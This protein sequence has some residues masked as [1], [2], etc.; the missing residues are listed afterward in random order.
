MVFQGFAQLSVHSFRK[1]GRIQAARYFVSSNRCEC[2]LKV[3]A[4]VI[5]AVNHVK[6]SAACFQFYRSKP[7][8]SEIAPGVNS[9]AVKRAWEALPDPFFQA[10]GPKEVFSAEFEEWEP[11]IGAEVQTLRDRWATAP[12]T[13]ADLV[14]ATRPTWLYP[15]EIKKAFAQWSSEQAHDEMLTLAELRVYAR[16]AEKIS[17]EGLI[18]D[19][20]PQ[21]EMPDRALKFFQLHAESGEAFDFHRVSEPRYR[22]AVFAHI[23]SGHRRADDFQCWIERAG[24]IAL[25]IDI[26]FNIEFGDLARPE[27]F[28]MF[29]Q[30]MEDGILLGFLGGPPCETWSKASGQALPDGSSGPRIVR[31]LAQPSGLP[32]L[33]K[34]EDDQVST[35]SRLLSVAIRLLVVAVRTGRC[36]ILEHPAEDDND[37]KLVSIWRL[38]ILRF[39]LKFSACRKVTV[40]QGYYGAKAVKPTDFF[41]VHITPDAEQILLQMRQTDLPKT[42]AIGKNT[43]N[44]WRTT[45]L[46]E[47]PPRLC[48]T[49]ALLFLKSQPMKAGSPEV[50]EW[51]LQST[52]DLR[53]MFDETVGMGQDFHGKVPHDLIRCTATTG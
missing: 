12:V 24:A 16:F 36:A 6:R 15:W 17:Y 1:H 49:L 45:E 8:V 47:Y 35:G 23:F 46:K 52:R 10:E 4:S 2:C 32:C 44:T 51:F 37:W 13:L 20:E 18:G 39:L 22:P 21:P 53:A 7:C 14:L 34:R 19:P 38:A 29:V 30:A 27:T 50:P 28:N 40:L 48:E 3:Y 26:V 41:L 42:A 25:S 43:D 9:R 11:G 5:H 33:T 31:S